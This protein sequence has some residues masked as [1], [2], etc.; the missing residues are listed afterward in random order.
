MDAFSHAQAVSARADALAPEEIACL[1]FI[2]ERGNPPR[3]PHLRDAGYPDAAVSLLV[4]RGLVGR[5]EHGEFQVTR[6]GRR[7][8]NAEAK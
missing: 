2:A 4:F 8:L 7:F 1:A 5:N 6:S 3:I